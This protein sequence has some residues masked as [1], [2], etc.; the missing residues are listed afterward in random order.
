MDP[1]HFYSQTHVHCWV[2]WASVVQPAPSP[3]TAVW[4]SALT[5]PGETLHVPPSDASYLGSLNYLWV[6]VAWSTDSPEVILH[7]LNKPLMVPILTHPQYPS[8]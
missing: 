6:T 3:G 1:Y 5:L 2:L 4:P 7:M 8:P